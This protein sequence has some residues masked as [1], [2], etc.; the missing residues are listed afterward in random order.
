MPV[1]KLKIRLGTNPN[2]F[3]HRTSSTTGP[4]PL[5]ATLISTLVLGFRPNCNDLILSLVLLS[6]CWSFE[7][8][9]C[10]P[11][12]SGSY[13]KSHFISSEIEGRPYII[14]FKQV[15]FNDQPEI[16]GFRKLVE[17]EDT[18]K[19]TNNFV[20]NDIHLCYNSSKISPT[21]NLR[22]AKNVELS[23]N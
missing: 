23:Q 15:N 10:S 21:R 11:I 12:E 7:N 8:H 17:F 2:A 13:G 22:V 1:E 5:V 19:E 14:Y 6:E 20:N 18:G 3:Y 9:T 16:H 4:S